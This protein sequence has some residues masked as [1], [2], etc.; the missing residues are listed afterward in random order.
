MCTLHEMLS[1]STGAVADNINSCSLMPRLLFAKWENS[2]VN[3]LYCFGSIIT[4]MLSQL[5]CEFKD[6]LVSSVACIQCHGIQLHHNVLSGCHLTAVFDSC[7]PRQHLDGCSVTRP[8][9]YTHTQPF[10]VAAC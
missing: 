3:C 2:L 10:D 8:F 4:M 6:A 1:I 9:L 7:I 5:D